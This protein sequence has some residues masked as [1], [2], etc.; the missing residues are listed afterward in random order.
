MLLRNM[1]GQTHTTSI[2]MGIHYGDRFL[3]KVALG[4]GA[5]VLK[6]DFLLSDSAQLL[7]K[8]IWTK[9]A[10]ERNKLPIGGTGFFGGLDND[11]KQILNWPGGHAIILV[12]TG[13][14][15][16]LYTSFYE[17]QSA[18]IRVSSEPEHWNGIVNEGLIFVISPGLQRFVGPKNIGTYIAHK[19]EPD[20]KDPD[21]TRLE[22]EMK[23]IKELPPF[24]I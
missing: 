24:D 12:R 23:N 13:R 7:R 2:K 15:L 3:A 4:I 11:L 17:T 1:S 20:L 16:N 10:E 8:F 14:T 5:L 21:F 9:N 22:G 6:K 18:V 19:F